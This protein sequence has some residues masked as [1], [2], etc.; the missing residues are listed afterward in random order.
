MALLY[1]NAVL[2]PRPASEWKQTPQGKQPYYFHLKHEA[3][4]AFAGLYNIWRNAQGNEIKTYTIIT[5]DPNTT[6]APIHDRMPVILSRE[7]EKTWLNPDITVPEQLLP[8]LIPYPDNDMETY[9]VSNAVNNVRN[10]IPE[11]MKPL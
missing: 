9:R 3:I 2:F 7:A 11:L 8:L 6:V 4:F 10:D 5:T 1:K